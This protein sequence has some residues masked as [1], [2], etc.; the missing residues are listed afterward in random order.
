MAK[1]FIGPYETGTQRNL[2][3]LWLPNEAFETLE[4]V[5]VWRGRVRKKSGYSTLGRLNDA[6]ATAT[7][8]AIGNA[9][10]G[11]ST[12]S[13]GAWAAAGDLPLAPGSVAINV[14]V[15]V[16]LWPANITLVDNG[17]GTLTASNAAIA[18]GYTLCYGTINYETGTFD[19]YFDP[20]LPVGGPFAV[21]VTAFRHLP[22]LSAMGLGTYEQTNINREELIAFDEDFSYLYNTATGVFDPLVDGAAV[23]QEWS[24]SN[25]DFFWT[26]NYYQDNASN[27]LFWATNNIANSIVAGQTRDGIQ[28]YNGTN[29]T[30][31]TP[32]ID[33]TPNELRGCLILVSYKDR[34]I[35]LNTLE[36]LVTPA[37]ATRHPNRA[38]WSQNGVPYTTTLGGADANAWRDDIVGRGGFIDAPT[39]EAIVSAGFVKD[40]LLVY[41]ERSTWQ[42][43]YTGNELLP[44]VWEQINAELGSES[45]FSSV[46]FDKGVMTV[47]DKGIYAS[48][49]INVER[50][51]NKVPSLVFNIHNDNEGPAR[52]HGIRDFYN[53]LVYWCY[54]DDDTDGTFPNKTI[55]LNYAEGSYSIF[56]D[57][58]TCFGYWQDVTDYTW[59]TLPFDTWSSWDIPW[60]SP[61]GQSYF[62]S[63]VAGNQKG[64]ILRLN[65]GIEN[66]AYADI[67]SIT[68]A[69]PAVVQVANHNLNT[70]QF[71]KFYF[72][73]G[74]TENVVAE[75]VGT[76]VAGSTSFTGTLANIGVF[77][78]SAPTGGGPN[79]VSI[80][81][82]ALIFTDLGNGTL[83]ESTLGVLTGT[84]DYENS[85]FTINF[86]ALGVDTAVTAD[87][88]YNILNYRVF[89]AARLTD[90]TFSI[91][92]INQ[93]SGL[94]E[95]VDLSGY[96]AAYTG[97]GEISQIS[98]FKAKTKK[99]NPHLETGS[100]FRMLYYDMLM[101]KS[102]MTFT[103]NIYAD[104]DDN[105]A[106][107]QL[108]VTC[109]DET[110]SGLAK[111]KTWK[112]VYANTN[113]DFVQLEFELSRIQ[114]T[115]R[116]NYASDFRFHAMLIETLATGRQVNRS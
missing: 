114:I 34:M 16:A 97:S 49:A 75:A 5:Y 47:G 87:Y 82:G 39:R 1:T 36:G 105:Q 18:G 115:D 107:L 21:T 108:N 88:S 23:V 15:G 8:V 38:R 64:F 84:I 100:N 54:P 2:E 28:I 43:R 74:F 44:F 92:S 94:T 62:P 90:N 14:A 6:G 45:T 63:I 41:F 12:F 116:D 4:D 86:G 66:G 22:R 37:G 9:I 20:V 57:S 56:N 59:A 11:N 79:F 77:P 102:D 109:A 32:Q 106:V 48:S 110:G 52:V 50:I 60:G 67:E 46:M 3:P 103:S 17:N 27:Y 78:A 69:N 68:N 89:Y 91:Y 42:L 83:L 29:W 76:A 31:Q 53:E 13:S 72:T 81:I 99:F 24:G 98:N 113:S 96:G 58:F 7:P 85:T 40:T 95:A 73:R 35:A 55:C 30:A 70:G 10:S 80:Q 19:L 93:T 25:S 51:D 61:I 111:E 112:R 71:I 26:W 101:S 104:E 65:Q 33:A